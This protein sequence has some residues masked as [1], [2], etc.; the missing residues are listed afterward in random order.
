MNTNMSERRKRVAMIRKVLQFATLL[1]EIH[2]D[3]WRIG[4]GKDAAPKDTDDLSRLDDKLREATEHHARIKGE[5]RDLFASTNPP[6]LTAQRFNEVYT[7]FDR[8]TATCFDGL[9]KLQYNLHIPLKIGETPAPF[10][11]VY[12]AI[13]IEQAKLILKMAAGEIGHCF[14]VDEEEEAIHGA[15]TVIEEYI[16]GDKFENISNSTIVNRSRV[17]RAFNKTEERLGDDIA[18]AILEI[19]QYVDQ[20]GNSAAGAV[21]DQF[22]QE[23]GEDKPDKSK[24]RQYWDGLIAIIPDIV[25]LAGAGAAIA[26]LF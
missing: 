19:A 12:G 13:D 8:E 9:L 26:S 2:L 7:A 21:F 4:F 18:S 16:V 20:S 5:L 14:P 25:K 24:L 15:G 6:E 22:V 10:S 17:E 3:I 11:M 23:A 1:E